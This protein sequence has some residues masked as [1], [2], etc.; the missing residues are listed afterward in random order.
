MSKEKIVK[1]VPVRLT[2]AESEIFETVAKYLGLRNDAEVFRYLMTRYY[3][4]NRNKLSLPRFEHFNLDE[5]GVKI[6]DRTD[7]NRKYVVQVFFK[8]EGVFCDYCK[9]DSCPHIQFAL[10]QSDVQEL[11]RK[12]RREGWKL[13]DV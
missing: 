6:L 11:I 4:E 2:R 1:I 8:P 9:T 5:H 12:K 10:E 3:Y 7:P 13:P